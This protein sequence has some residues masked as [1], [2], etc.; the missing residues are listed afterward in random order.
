MCTTDADC[1]AQLLLQLHR[2]DHV[3]THLLSKDLHEQQIVSNGG[4]HTLPA[5]ATIPK[6]TFSE[7]VNCDGS[8]NC[9]DFVRVV[10]D[11]VQAAERLLPAAKAR[12]APAT[13]DVGAVSACQAVNCAWCS[14]YLA[15]TY[16]A[17]RTVEM[18]IAPMRS[19]AATQ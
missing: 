2:L 9:R 17:V 8:C 14:T 12:A 11:Y 18:L 3:R 10:R 13:V 5:F 7:T 4:L 19:T 1:C 15:L 6:R 16:I